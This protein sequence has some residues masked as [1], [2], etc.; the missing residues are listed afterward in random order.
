MSKGRARREAINPTENDNSKKHIFIFGLVTRN[1]GGFMKK[2]EYFNYNF[3]GDCNT[4][5]S[6]V[7]SDLKELFE[8]C[9]KYCDSFVVRLVTRCTAEKLPSSLDK[10]RISIS[11]EISDM[12][13]EMIIIGS[14]EKQE[15]RRYKL[16]PEVKEF[17]LSFTDDLFK[18][19]R[20]GFEIQNPED[21]AFFREDGS[22]FFYSSIHDDYCELY[23]RDG[24]DVSHIVDKKNKEDGTD[25]WLLRKEF[26]EEDMKDMRTSDIIYEEW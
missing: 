21:P 16:S 17:I 20:R 23:V 12:Y 11:E 14:D 2:Y 6:F 18:W 1:K 25:R 9:F 5:Y 26:S 10:Y 8:T 3:Y 19:G 7:G 4:D 15:L 22:L 24:E 13:G